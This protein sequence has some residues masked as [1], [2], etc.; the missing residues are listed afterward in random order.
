MNT[1]V[2]SVASDLRS[3]A[4]VDYFDLAKNAR[5][6]YKEVCTQG[7]NADPPKLVEDDKYAGLHGV[8]WIDRKGEGWYG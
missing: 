7:F 1:T 5:T 4:R 8:W 2:K 6:F 3:S